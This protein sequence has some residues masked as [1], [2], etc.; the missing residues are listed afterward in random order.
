MYVL[1]WVLI[2]LALPVWNISLNL[3]SDLSTT[4]NPR[5]LELC[6]VY[7]YTSIEPIPTSDSDS[8]YVPQWGI[9]VGI[10]EFLYAFT[11]RVVVQVTRN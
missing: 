8:V 9:L 2:P 1:V 11:V 4:Q 3:E 6:K 7:S 5:S 10:L